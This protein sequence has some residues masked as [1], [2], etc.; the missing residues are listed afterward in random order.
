MANDLLMQGPA[1]DKVTE[2]TIG[3]TKKF[4]TMSN[5]DDINDYV[6]TYIFTPVNQ[7]Q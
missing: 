4:A 5:L 1:V 2:L 6:K 7:Q 3:E